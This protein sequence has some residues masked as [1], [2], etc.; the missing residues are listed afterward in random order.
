MSKLKYNYNDEIEKL[1]NRLKKLIQTKNSN[2]IKDYNPRREIK[3]N[4]FIKKYNSR[5]EQKIKLILSLYEH[6]KYA[7]YYIIIFWLFIIFSLFLLI[8]KY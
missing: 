8:H 1:D 5:R 3:K 7:I 2:I 6:N 4:D